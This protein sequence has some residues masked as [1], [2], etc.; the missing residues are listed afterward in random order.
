MCSQICTNFPQP[1]REKLC[2]RL[3]WDL[4]V[5][6]KENAELTEERKLIEIVFKGNL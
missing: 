1:C 5:Q 2:L 3:V 4:N 6:T